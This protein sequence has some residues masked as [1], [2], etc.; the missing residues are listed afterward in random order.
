MSVMFY[1]VLRSKKVRWDGIEGHGVFHC[2]LYLQQTT[3]ALLYHA[4]RQKL[5]AIILNR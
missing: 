4:D 1:N 2:Q 5:L 3:S